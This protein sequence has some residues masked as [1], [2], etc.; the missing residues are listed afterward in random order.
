MIDNKSSF[1]YRIFIVT[2]IK[3]GFLMI[4]QKYT[5][6]LLLTIFGASGC[7]STKKS[8]EP[9]TTKGL[10]TMVYKGNTLDLTT[11]K[12]GAEG[13]LYKT[14][15]QGS[16]KKPF[17][18]EV[19]TVHYI[20]CLHDGKGIVGNQFDSSVDRGTPF[21]FKLGI[22]QVIKGWDLMVADMQEGETRIVI[23][24]PLVAYGARGAGST[25]P[26]HATLIFEIQMIK[27]Q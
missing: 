3:K 15:I 17:R 8:Q 19:V 5:Y 25:I 10:K 12:Q 14:I 21:Q 1:Y 23:L 11:F 6:L 2:T 4:N 20:G 9:Q 26:P 27:A 24:P 13:I 16:G 7:V 22:G 18:G